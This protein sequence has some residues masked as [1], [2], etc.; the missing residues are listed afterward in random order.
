MARPAKKHAGLPCLLTELLIVLR[1]AVLFC[2]EEEYTEPDHGA[3]CSR[4]D[5]SVGV[6]E[7]QRN[8]NEKEDGF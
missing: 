6:F 5:G 4:D 8:D 2:N 1:S 3:V 7:R